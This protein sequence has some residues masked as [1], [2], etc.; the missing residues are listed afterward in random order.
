MVEKLEPLPPWTTSLKK[1][2]KRS[3]KVDVIKSKSLTEN[4]SR[5]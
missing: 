2:K 1:Q 3:F 4:N 5:I